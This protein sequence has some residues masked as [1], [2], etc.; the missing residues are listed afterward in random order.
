MVLPLKS[1]ERFQ[2]FETETIRIAKGDQVRIT[3]NGE[4]ANGKRLSNGNIFTVE[5]FT[6]KGNLVF[7]NG[8]ELAA[9]HGHLAHGYCATSH[10]SQSR[11]VRDV[12]VAQSS[13]SFVASSREQ[14]YVSV[15][16]GKESIR[17]YT[18]DLSGLQAA[19]GFSSTRLSGVELA[20]LK[21]KE[22]A[23][24][25]EALNSKQWRD[26]IKSRASEGATK[27]FVKNLMKERQ[28]DGF[29]KSESMN[30]RQYVEIRRGLISADGKSRSKGH[31][32]VAEKRNGSNLAQKRRS[33]LRPT[34]HAASVKAEIERSS[35]KDVKPAEAAK[36]PEGPR[37]RIG[38]AADA[39]KEAGRQFKQAAVKA[40]KK[41]PG[42]DNPPTKAKL[43]QSGLQQAAKH[44]VKAKA[45]ERVKRG[46]EARK[47]VKSKV[48][49]APTPAPKR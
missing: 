43:P 24:M 41:A 30:W 26:T 20:G 1:A 32:S 46:G 31:P 15:S 22:I 14:L 5:K 35:A 8:A 6:K 29:K 49:A 13:K 12:L 7:G 36:K 4:S 2:V 16:R 10:S 34:E 9:D 11:S 47:A 18:D 27:Q 39:L 28:Q 33:F 3:R 44:S 21:A 25:S 42:N 23:A 38:R 17:I 48:Q 40:V 19:V 37:T 45:A